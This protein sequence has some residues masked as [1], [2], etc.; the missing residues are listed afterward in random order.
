E[1]E[2][3]PQPKR[4]RTTIWDA[5]AGRVG[6]NGWLDP[7]PVYSKRRD[8]ASSSTRPISAEDV[9]YSRK[10]TGERPE[11]RDDDDLAEDELPP[12]E[13]TNAL[14]RYVSRWMARPEI[15]RKYLHKKS[16]D[17]SAMLAFGILLDETIEESIE[18]TG[19]L[20]FAEGE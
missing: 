17:F 4:R 16:F 5:V 20:A 13:L 6:P 18:E 8:T 7:E 19:H 15:Q 2:G 14:H 9:Y 12:S 10:N 11:R 3:S 1:T